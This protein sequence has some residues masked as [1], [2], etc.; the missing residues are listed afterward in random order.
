MTL[1]LVLL[2]RRRIGGFSPR[3]IIA[4]STALVWLD[5]SDL[6]TLF[7]D[8]A[9]TTPVTAPGQPVGLALDKS[10]GLVL[11][12]E[13]VTNGTFDTDIAGWTQIGGGSAV[14]DP[15]GGIACT[16]VGDAD[17]NVATNI[18][19]VAGRFYRATWTVRSASG[20]WLF[21]IRNSIDYQSAFLNTTGTFS[22][23][24]VA[25]VTG[26][27]TVN[28][29]SASN[30][31]TVV[32]DNIS[33]RELPGF[34]AT[35]SGTSRPT[36]G[37]VPSRGRVNLLER[38]E[39]LSNA[40]WTIKNSMATPT[41]SSGG[42]FMNDT[43]SSTFQGLDRSIT[44]DPTK[45]VFASIDVLKTTGTPTNYP[46]LQIVGISGT[47][48][49]A[50][51]L[52][53]NTTTGAVAQAYSDLALSPVVQNLGAFWRVSFG[54]SQ[55]AA[56]VRFDIF[57]AG[58]SDGT[59]IS[60]SA[61]GSAIFNRAQL[62]LGSTAS[63]YQRVGSQFD[64]TDPV[65]FPS[66][67]CHYLSFDGIDD[68][69][70]T[71]TITPNADKVQVF[72]GVRKLS[73]A[74]AGEIVGLSTSPAGFNGTFFLRAPS[75][76]APNYQFRSRG[77]TANGSTYTNALVAAPVTNVLCGIGDI[78]APNEV[79]RVNSVA[80]ASSTLTQGTGNYLA[81][82]LYIGRTGGTSNPFNG[83]LFGLVVRF[84]TANLDAGL[85]SQT[86]RWVAQKTPGVVI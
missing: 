49:P 67:P 18:T 20:F 24:F 66:Y 23:V 63:P 38:T 9:G 37:V 52:I 7:Q 25:S 13:L 72:A 79:L 82:P 14:W 51:G 42:W 11:G 65:G 8:A 46:L 30:G 75:Q 80:V 2:N 57:P 60:A 76:A 5:P 84:S 78:S 3:A 15:S 39:E 44:N 48:G 69:M 74:A 85:I 35:A 53:I 1:P 21:R 47:V 59:T 54:T 73:D 50:R 34:H 16:D 77:T 45:N 61:T 31:Q 6:T 28:L 29:I 27:N 43:N 26:T 58:S 12:P 62:E 33:V 19:T 83:Q 41:Q 22:A 55:T 71:P 10:Q 56:T 4:G 81:Y 70:V 36:Y 68:F 40:Y 86:E 64:V 32:F 17:C